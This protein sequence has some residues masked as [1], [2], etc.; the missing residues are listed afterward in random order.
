MALASTF[1]TFRYE[2]LRTIPWRR[3]GI[4]SKEAPPI[5]IA[6]VYYDIQLS[7]RIGTQFNNTFPEAWIS[8]APYVTHTQ[9]KV[10]QSPKLWYLCV[11]VVDAQDLNIAPIQPPLTEPE[12]RVKVRLGFQL[13][14]MRRGST[15]HRSLSFHWSEGK[16]RLPYL[17]KMSHLYIDEPKCDT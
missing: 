13:Q 12:V 4:A 5:R 6:R 9:S 8:Y 1:L 2:I 11:T 15:N 16:K 3:N 14:Q 7:M 17:I 10:Y